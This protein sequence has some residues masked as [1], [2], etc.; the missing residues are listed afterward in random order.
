MLL[1]MPFSPFSQHEIRTFVPGAAGM[2]QL[3]DSLAQRAG[4]LQAH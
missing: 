3:R 2:R 4:M 1:E